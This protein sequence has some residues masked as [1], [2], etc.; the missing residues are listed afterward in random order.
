M[1][2]LRR[3][4]RGVSDSVLSNQNTAGA[5]AIHPKGV[6]S[7]WCHKKYVTLLRNVSEEYRG[8]IEFRDTVLMYSVPR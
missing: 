1:A 7:A 3:T 8:L 4:T 2:K 6:T 5:L